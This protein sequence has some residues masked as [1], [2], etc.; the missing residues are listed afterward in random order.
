M[1]VYIAGKIT[2]DDN[3]KGK[4]N[5]AAKRFEDE[6]DVVLNP[7]ILPTGMASEDYMRIC[8]AMIDSADMVAFLPDWE[9][10]RGA[11][12]EWQYCQ[13]ISKQTFYMG[14]WSTP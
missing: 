7:A 2:G 8:F 10:S 5:E 3:Y 14:A 11:M 9:H 12:L 4:F 1:K 13:Y 6:G